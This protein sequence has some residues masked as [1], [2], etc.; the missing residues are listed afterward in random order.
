MDSSTKAV[1][2]VIGVKSKG[3]PEVFCGD[4]E[5]ANEK[6]KQNLQATKVV[7]A[8]GE[9]EEDIKTNEPLFSSVI[10]YGGGRLINSRK[11]S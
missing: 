9:E 3:S 5:K 2:V 11:L 10:W 7:K 8:K 1:H 4:A 6:W